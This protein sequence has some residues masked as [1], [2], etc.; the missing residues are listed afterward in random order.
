MGSNSM[1]SFVRVVKVPVAAG[2][3]ILGSVICGQTAE[4]PNKVRETPVTTQVLADDF[5]SSLTAVVVELAPGAKP[6]RHDHAGTM[7][8]YVLK[9]T[10]RSQLNDRKLIEYRAGQHW[11][12]PPGAQLTT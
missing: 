6:A 4:K 1:T 10:V 2:L 12:E 3:L 8:A 9:G 7:F 5:G 11:I